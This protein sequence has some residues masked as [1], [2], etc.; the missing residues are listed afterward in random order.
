M[1]HTC[2]AAILAAILVLISGAGARADQILDYTLTAQGASTPLATW[3][4]SQT[5]T[6]TCPP[7]LPCAIPGVYFTENVNVSLNGGPAILDTLVFL[8]SGFFSGLDLNDF[9][10]SIP[11]FLGPQLYT[12]SESAPLMTIGSFSLTDDGTSGGVAGTKYTLDV[13]AVP[14]SSTLLLLVIGLSCVVLALYRRCSH[15]TEPSS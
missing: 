7:S 8:N 5:P 10:F 2:R 3:Q 14:E 1:K 12:G 15:P 4:M 11:E 13:K 6:P 9:N